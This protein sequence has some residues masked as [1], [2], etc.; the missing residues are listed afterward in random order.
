[1][2]PR[3]LK[4]GTTV[5]SVSAM[6]VLEMW[7]WVEGDYYWIGLSK[8]KVVIDMSIRLITKYSDVGTISTCT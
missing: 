7:I 1:L 2:V 5:V 3:F 8:T 6:V 4:A